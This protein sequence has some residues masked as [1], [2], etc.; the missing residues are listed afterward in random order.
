MQREPEGSSFGTVELR[1]P[2]RVNWTLS[3][4]LAAR[5]AE[6]GD[7][8]FIREMP[9]RT[10]TFA[11]A[12]DLA[13]RAAGGLTQAGLAPGDRVVIMSENSIEFIVGW[14][15][16]ACAGLVEVPVSPYYRGVG[17]ERL[18]AQVQ[19]AA[20]LCTPDLVPELVESGAIAHVARVYLLPG[21]DPATA[22]A[23][24]AGVSGV[25][26][27][28][29]HDL[30]DH[31]RIEGHVRA[32]HELASVLFTSGT[33]GLPKGVAMPE[34]QLYFYSE[35]FRNYE[36]LDS[37]DVWLH[38]KPMYTGLSHFHVVYASLIAGC[39]VALYERFSARLWAQRVSNSGATIV[40]LLGEM[41]DFA[42][43]QPASDVDHAN[44]LRCISCGPTSWAIADSFL[45][46]FG[47]ETLAEAYGQTEICLPVMTP[48]GARRPVG[49]C[50]LIVDDWF[51]VRLAD[52]V[53]DVEV[54]PGELGEMQVR[55]REPWT[56]CD[57]YYL[58]AEATA[59]ATR[60]LWFHTGDIFRRDGDG[61]FHFIDRARDVIR[62]R[63]HNISSKEIEDA[64]LARDDVLG[65]A[66]VSIAPSASDESTEVLAVIVVSDGAAANEDLVR[67]V[68]QRLPYYAVPRYI[69]RVDGLPLTPSGKIRKAALRD[70]A[71]TAD[72]WDRQRVGL[73]LEHELAV[74]KHRRARQI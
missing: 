25:V 26:V 46:R 18:I 24:L 58:D 30:Y 42:M 15:A 73:L 6:S 48:Y 44:R 74:N 13:R 50:G 10:L 36:R 14:F 57:G 1:F 38:D 16:T 62:R 45:A 35:Q 11:E 32:P 41:M 60:N 71:V 63:G 55:H 70:E 7:R 68:E 33:T 34:A 39:Q 56:L 3:R 72:T 20:A 12:D 65:C 67:F 59:A 47:G 43:K 19:P 2:D 27:E 49:A 40:L 51:D 29:F 9:S 5:A 53:T 23:I 4:V 69:R 28:N 52:P 31:P 66:A 8:V 17:L 37:Q 64:F 61:W 22:R 21:G 54:A